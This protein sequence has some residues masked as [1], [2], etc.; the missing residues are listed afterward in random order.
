[1]FIVHTV[2]L[3]ENPSI[4]NIW[5]IYE[6]WIYNWSFKV[7]S[8]LKC[9]L[10]LCTN[11][12]SKAAVK[13]DTVL[14][15]DSHSSD[16]I[17]TVM[18]DYLNRAVTFGVSCIASGPWGTWE[19]LSDLWPCCHS[20]N[21]L[22]VSFHMQWCHLNVLIILNEWEVLILAKN[23][24]SHTKN[25]SVRYWWHLAIPNDVCT[26]PLCKT[27]LSYV[28]YFTYTLHVILSTKWQPIFLLW[29]LSLSLSPG[30]WL[31]GH[32]PGSLRGFTDSIISAWHRLKRAAVKPQHR[33]GG[34]HGTLSQKC[35]F[36]TC[37]WKK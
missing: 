9:V 12:L 33:R 26:C 7:T 3:T 20:A 14:R 34:T 10:E 11:D 27:I 37:Q 31:Q 2:G 15:K 32:I 25:L 22:S 35:H 24:F 19:I 1:M 30:L 18:Y 23:S 29:S 16:T 36:A 21:Q 8:Q 6:L 13:P 28:S 17:T 5:T 4:F